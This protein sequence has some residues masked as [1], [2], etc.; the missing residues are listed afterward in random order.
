MAA[1]NA[2]LS[3]V[4]V[5]DTV[6]NSAGVACLPSAPHD[7]DAIGVPEAP[8]NSPSSAA[9]CPHD[10]IDNALLIDDHLSECTQESHLSA[11]TAETHVSVIVAETHVS[12]ITEETHVSLITEDSMLNTR[13]LPVAEEVASSWMGPRTRSQSPLMHSPSV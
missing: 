5:A 8:T 3:T 1:M 12:A 2:L 13:P 4:T 6:T 11:C 9:P 7:N 10:A